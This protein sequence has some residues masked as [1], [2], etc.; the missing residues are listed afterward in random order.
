MGKARRA[1]VLR[2]PVGVHDHVHPAR[3]WRGVLGRRR[4]RLR[5]TFLST[6]P[7]PHLFGRSVPR[8]SGGR[9]PSRRRLGAVPTCKLGLSWPE[10]ILVITSDPVMLMGHYPLTEQGPARMAAARHVRCLPRSSGRTGAR[11]QRGPIGPFDRGMRHLHSSPWWRGHLWVRSGFPRRL[12]MSLR[13]ELRCSGI[14]DNLR[15]PRR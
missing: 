1:R 5:P 10:A 6:A 15:R 4:A 8:I 9:R 11:I 3:R 13:P 7:V 14:P 12:Q 2:L